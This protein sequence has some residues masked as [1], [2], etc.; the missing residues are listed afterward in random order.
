MQ[1]AIDWLSLFWGDVEEKT[2]GASREEFSFFSCVDCR[3][4]SYLH[5]F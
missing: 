1:Q 4:S 3:M 5:F 2:L